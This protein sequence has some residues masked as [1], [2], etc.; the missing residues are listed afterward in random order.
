MAYFVYENWTH[1]RAR[2]HRAHCGYCNDGRGTQP[3]DS[4]RNGK[5]HGPYD[6]RDLAFRVAKNLRR[7]D[8]QPCGICA[9]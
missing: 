3:S 8:T 7:V 6:D 1:D 5:W 2:I 4:G 9:P